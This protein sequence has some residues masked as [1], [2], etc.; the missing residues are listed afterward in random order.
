MKALLLG[1]DDELIEEVEVKGNPLCL[2]IPRPINCSFGQRL[3]TIS[4]PK[5]KFILSDKESEIY[6]LLHEDPVLIYKKIRN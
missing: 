2:Y 6:S 4:L 5:D 1:F 3:G